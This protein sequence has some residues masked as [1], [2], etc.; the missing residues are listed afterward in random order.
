M[1]LDDE[2]DGSQVSLA[3][4]W[5][6]LVDFNVAIMIAT[7]DAVI[8]QMPNTS[9]SYCIRLFDSSEKISERKRSN[10]LWQRT[11]RTLTYVLLVSP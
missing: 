3:L 2:D 6:W 1:C 5:A 9:V 4:A 11:T 8:H 10:V 7:A